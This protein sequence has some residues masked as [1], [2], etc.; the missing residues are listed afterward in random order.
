MDDNVAQPNVIQIVKN[1][2]QYQIVL[3]QNNDRI[4]Y[5]LIFYISRRKT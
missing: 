4:R 2:D 1:I 5:N 3:I